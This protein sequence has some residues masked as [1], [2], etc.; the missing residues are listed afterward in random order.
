MLS[1][2]LPFALRCSGWRNKL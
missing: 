2:Y 1:L